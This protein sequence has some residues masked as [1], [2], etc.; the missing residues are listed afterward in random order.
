MYGDQDPG[1]IGLLVF[2]CLTQPLAGMIL[3]IFMAAPHI[4]DAIEVIACVQAVEWTDSPVS[5]ELRAMMK[6]A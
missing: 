6:A 1:S 5:T 2:R 3:C 4:C